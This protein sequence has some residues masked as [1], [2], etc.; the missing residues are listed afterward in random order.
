MGPSFL[1]TIYSP[2]EISP[3]P[4]PLQQQNYHLASRLLSLAFSLPKGKEKQN[5][6]KEAFRT[7]L[8]MPQG[9]ERPQRSYAQLEEAQ[10]P[11]PVVCFCAG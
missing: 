1:Y 9:T 6:T 2:Q 8:F 7:K 10:V 5:K 3:F 4:V 11:E